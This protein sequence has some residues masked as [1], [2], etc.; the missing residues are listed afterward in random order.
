[1]SR[2][3]PRVS[4][5]NRLA[6]PLLKLNDPFLNAG[7]LSADIG[8]LGGKT[9]KPGAFRFQRLKRV[10]QKSGLLFSPG[11]QGLALQVV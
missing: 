1:M 2:P 5:R 11:L 7:F 9:G 10:I 8:I 4:R 3:L 6:L